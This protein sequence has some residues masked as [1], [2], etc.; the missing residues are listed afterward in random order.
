MHNH[1]DWLT[2]TDVFFIFLIYAAI[3]TVILMLW[4]L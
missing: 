1:D 2:W 3:T 4:G